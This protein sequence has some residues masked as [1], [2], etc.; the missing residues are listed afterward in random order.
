MQTTLI[1]PK[2]A[3]YVQT[4]TVGRG[5]ALAKLFGYPTAN[6]HC[7]HPG[8]SGTYAGCVLFEGIAH[9]AAVYADR[10]RRLLESHIFDFSGNLYGMEITVMLLEKIA[11]AEDIHDRESLRA[12][13]AEMI[14]KTKR[15]FQVLHLEEQPV[16]RSST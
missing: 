1:T 9:Q 7:Q 14:D 5:S 10:K 12:H 2:E 6:V 15:Y 4:G 11:D 8:L 3:L 16:A 13:I